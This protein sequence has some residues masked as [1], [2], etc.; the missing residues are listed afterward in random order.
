MNNNIEK[1]IEKINEVNS[2]SKIGDIDKI[3]LL[4][5]HKKRRI[6]FNAL[7]KEY[8]DRLNF[9]KDDVKA[10]T[11]QEN[12]SKINDRLRADKD[13][14]DVNE[15]F[16][17][18]M[19][20]AIQSFRD[21]KSSLNEKI[22][23]LES[24]CQ[25]CK[26]EGKVSYLYIAKLGVGIRV[27]KHA[28]SKLKENRI[29]AKTIAKNLNFVDGSMYLDSVYNCKTGTG[30]VGTLIKENNFITENLKNEKYKHIKN[31]IIKS[32][33]NNLTN[34]NVKKGFEDSKITYNKA[35][36]FVNSLTEMSKLK[37]NGENSENL[38]LLGSTRDITNKMETDVK[39]LL[40]KFSKELV[41]KKV[42]ETGLKNLADKYNH[43]LEKLKTD[44][45]K[46]CSSDLASL[47]SLASAYF[48]MYALSI[49]FRF[50]SDISYNIN[51]R[52]SDKRSAV[53]N[54]KYGILDLWIAKSIIPLFAPLGILILI[55]GIIRLLSVLLDLKPKAAPDIVGEELVSSEAEI[56]PS[57]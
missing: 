31:N 44:Y 43:E 22:N 48:D 14:E 56:S 15:F 35:Q 24:A 4:P 45:L 42:T 10:N 17:L 49:S 6:L 7:I 54:L 5:H 21:G 30:M 37:N 1:V 51:Q 16:H 12:Y 50:Y 34:S 18:K 27:S 41:S 53:N 39:N 23:K 40:E 38:N 13:A 19:E 9:F 55:V 33:T 20:E 52:R 36:Q 11:V 29:K 57:L 47:A 32:H 3:P 26:T 8:N 46:S 25:K 2:L 28:L